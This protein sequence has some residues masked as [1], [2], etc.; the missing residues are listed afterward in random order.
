MLHH[1]VTQDRVKGQMRGHLRRRHV[2]ESASGAAFLSTVRKAA[3]SNTEAVYRHQIVVG[4]ASH[5]V[6]TR[7]FADSADSAAEEFNADS[8]GLSCSCSL[9]P[10][11]L[12]RRGPPAVAA[13]TDAFTWV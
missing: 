8:V 1:C 12:D 5:S 7:V 6:G 13:P 11:I 9:S 3:I 2:A 4:T 10:Q